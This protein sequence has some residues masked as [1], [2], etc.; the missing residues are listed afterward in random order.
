[1][2]ASKTARETPRF[3][4]AGHRLCSHCSKA[5]SANAGAA[6]VSANKMAMKNRI[7]TEYWMPRFRGP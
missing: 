3:C 2:P 1:M 6:K 4:A 5:A 7:V